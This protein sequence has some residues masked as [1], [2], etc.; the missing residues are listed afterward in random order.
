MGSYPQGEWVTFQALTSPSHHTQNYDIYIH[1][2]HFNFIHSQ[3]PKPCL[4]NREHGL[5]MP[6]G[7]NALQ[8]TDG[9]RY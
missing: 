6:K 1:A 5:A 3:R 2:L 7:P 9:R 4:I 8:Q